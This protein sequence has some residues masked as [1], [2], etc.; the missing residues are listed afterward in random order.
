MQG[1]TGNMFLRSGT[2]EDL[3]LAYELFPGMFNNMDSNIPETDLNNARYVDAPGMLSE[4][5]W[6]L[7]MLLKLEHPDEQ[8]LADSMWLRTTRTVRD[9]SSKIRCVQ[10]FGYVSRPA[11]PGD[12]PALSPCNCGCGGNALPM[13]TWS[14]GRFRRMADFC[15]YTAWKPHCPCLELGDRPFQRKAYVHWCGEPDLYLHAGGTGPKYVFWAAG[16]AV[17]GRRKLPA[18]MSAAYENYLL[19]NCEHRCRDRPA[20]PE[21]LARSYSHAGRVVPGLFP[22][23]VSERCSRMQS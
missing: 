4:L 8:G 1:I 7:D 3:L 23:S 20:L 14:I 5:K 12:G 10:H 13:R 16:I 19:A 21:R 9:L 22:L 2:V 15:R 18:A 17:P 11:T 6:E